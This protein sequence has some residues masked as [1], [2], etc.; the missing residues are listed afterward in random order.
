VRD[1]DVPD[2]P[3]ARRAVDDRRLVQLR[4]NARQ[5]REIDDRV[6]AD[7]LPQAG[8]DVDVRE[9]AAD[10]QKIRRRDV[11][12]RE[13]L[14]EYAPR[15]EEQLD[16][17]D[18]YD[19]GYEVRRV[20]HVL[21]DLHEP[22]AFQFVEHDGEDD[23]EGE[24]DREAVKVQVNSIFYY[25]P[26]EVAV[27]ECGE[28]LEQRI[29]PGASRDAGAQAEIL[30]RELDPVERRVFEHDEIYDRRSEEYI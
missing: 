12:Q 19:D 14:V 24:A 18:E 6:V 1:V 2:A 28:M 17:A 30:E 23:R 15:R 16:H 29:S 9:Q 5:R 27:K 13:Q 20:G 25:R 3:D 4:R 10:G 7:V 21:H 8:P 11:Y 22:L 26:E